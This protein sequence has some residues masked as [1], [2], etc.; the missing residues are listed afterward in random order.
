MGWGNIR[1]GEVAVKRLIGGRVWCFGDM[2]IQLGTMTV[3]ALEK[4]SRGSSGGRLE[5]EDGATWW[6]QPDEIYVV[7]LI[8]VNVNKTMNYVNL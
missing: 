8:K 4:S 1:V 3:V 2:K 5:R 7:L 6:S